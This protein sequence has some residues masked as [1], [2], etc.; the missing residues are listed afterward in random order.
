MKFWAALQAMINSARVISEYGM[1]D[2][3]LNQPEDDCMINTYVGA[4]GTRRKS[5]VTAEELA[6]RWNI[7]IET[8]RKI[9]QVTTQRGIRQAMH[10]MTRR[11][12]TDLMQN[13]Y[14]RLNDTWYTDTMFLTHKS[15]KG[16]TC[17]QVFTN[18]RR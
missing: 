3:I 18:C 9:I 4:I 12:R 15:I 8:A 17:S 2:C 16:E 14:K 1:D 10:P 5:A 13:K 7:G 11:Y 6:R